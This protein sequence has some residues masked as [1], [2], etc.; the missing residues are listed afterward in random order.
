MC[1]TV[2]MMMKN[3]KAIVTRSVSRFAEVMGLSPLNVREIKIRK[4][5]NYKIIEVVKHKK[6][7]TLK[8]AEMSDTYSTN[9]VAILNQH[10][11]DIPTTL[12]LRILVSLGVRAKTH[13]KPAA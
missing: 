6:L 2:C 3:E 9:V 1:D 5:L 8:V 12:M 10:I 4:K 13:F 7:S 11:H